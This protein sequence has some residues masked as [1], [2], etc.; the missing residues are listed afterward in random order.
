MNY[1]KINT[2]TNYPMTA[3]KQVDNTWKDFTI[4]EDGVYSPSELNDAIIAQNN[5]QE[6]ATFRAER[7]QL[8]DEVDIEINK[9][10][11]NSLDT[12]A[13]RTY[14]QALRDAT[15]QWVL[16]AKPE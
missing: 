16:P 5:L 9:A 2:E 14:R 8:L 13:L 7:N 1:Y 6:Q 11:D 10:E 12:T 15:V 3:T 4:D